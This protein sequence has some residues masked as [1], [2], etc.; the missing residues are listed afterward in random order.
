MTRRRRVPAAT[1]L[2]D[3]TSKVH[4]EG[5]RF[6]GL[7]ISCV[8]DVGQEEEIV[9]YLVLISSKDAILII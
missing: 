9:S 7:A 2:S 4:V 1:L 6:S 5:T 3:T 8:K